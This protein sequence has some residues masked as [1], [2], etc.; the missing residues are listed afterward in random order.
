MDNG[1]LFRSPKEFRLLLGLGRLPQG[2]CVLLLPVV[3]L[4]F[5]PE[6]CFAAVRGLRTMYHIHQILIT[7]S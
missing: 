5:I 7:F 4:S 1:H 3:Q 2:S 6:N